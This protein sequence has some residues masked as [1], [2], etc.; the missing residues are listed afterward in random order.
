ERGGRRRKGRG[1]EA[2]RSGGAATQGAGV[3]PVRREGD[4][5]AWKPEDDFNL[6]RLL[7]TDGGAGSGGESGD[8]KRKAVRT[9]MWGLPILNAGSLK[10]NGEDPDAYRSRG[11]DGGGRGRSGGGD[12]GFGGRSSGSG[13]GGSSRSGGGS[14]GSAAGGTGSRRKKAASGESAQATPAPNAGGTGSAGEGVSSG[15]KSRKKK[16]NGNSTAAFVRKKRL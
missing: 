1:G 8:G 6:D 5:R 7:G 16:K 13:R 12:R 15:T 9:D 11:R 2:G 10:D 4:A 3:A 14:G